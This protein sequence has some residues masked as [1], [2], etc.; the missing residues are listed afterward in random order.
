MSEQHCDRCGRPAPDQESAD[1][2]EWEAVGD[3][4][5][6]LC[7]DCITPAEH[8]AMIEDMPRTDDTCEI[9]G[10]DEPVAGPE[11]GLCKGHIIRL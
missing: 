6:V 1:F 2:T 5:T 11:Y 9:D 3:G 10:C 7:P 8:Q 4:T